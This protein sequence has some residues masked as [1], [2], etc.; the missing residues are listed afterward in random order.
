MINEKHKNYS[1]QRE[2]NFI[3]PSFF[4]SQAYLVIVQSNLM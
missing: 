1:I 3:L 2:T 4:L